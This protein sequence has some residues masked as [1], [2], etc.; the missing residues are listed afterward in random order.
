MLRWI[1]ILKS[2]FHF[3]F[4]QKGFASLHT[5]AY[6]NSKEC[7]KLLLSAGADVNIAGAVSD[8]NSSC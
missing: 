7:M 8:D 5:A 2:R 6:Y 3:V 1:M 4:L